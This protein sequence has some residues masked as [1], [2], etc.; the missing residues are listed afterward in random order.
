MLRIVT[1]GATDFPA[2]WEEEFDIQI[3][4]INIHFGEETFLQYVEMSLDEFY[5]KI[6]T[7]RVF[8]KTSQPSPHQ[9][10]EFYKTVADE[11]D[12][13]LSIHVTSKLSGTYASAVTAAKELKDKYNIVTFDSAGGSLG[14]AFMCRAARQMEQAGKSVEEIMAYLEIVREKVQIIFTLDN[15]EYAR[16]SG[17]VGTL[18]AALA[19][20]LNIKPIAV[21]ED[22]VLNMV[23]KVRTR[24]AAIKQVLEMGKEAFGDQPVHVGVAHA[25]DPES[26]MKLSA[27]AKKLFNAKDVV[28]SDLSISLAINLGPGT[29]GLLLY[30]ADE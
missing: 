16:R 3:I 19:S 23:D 18:S 30:P 12:T 5:D 2:G 22:G 10:T 8:P 13:I 20:I 15:L 25:R 24:K 26:A 7:S 27:E 28:Q 6:E 4:P 14:I 17:R 9:F 11:G 1:D 21:L 29:V